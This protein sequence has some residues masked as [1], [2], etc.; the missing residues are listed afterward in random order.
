[1]TIVDALIAV[2]TGDTDS[3]PNSTPSRILLAQDPVALDSYAL[4]LINQLRA[5]LPEPANKPVNAKLTGW[6]GNAA[7]LGLGS[8][9]FSLIKA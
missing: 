3:S 7:A 1:M 5:S 2:T 9:N 4:V 8:T 6:L